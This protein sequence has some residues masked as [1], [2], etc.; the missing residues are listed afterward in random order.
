MA[1]PLELNRQM[2]SPEL[3]R[4]LGESGIEVEAA[5][6]ALEPSRK[7]ASSRPRSFRRRSLRLSALSAVLIALVAAR[8]KA[9]ATPTAGDL[10]EGTYQVA[11]VKR[12]DVLE[13]AN[14]LEVRLLGVAPASNSNPDA[15]AF[16]RDSVSGSE[17]RLQF[18]R[19]RLDADGRYLAYVWVAGP[20]SERLL[21]EELFRAG[22]V[23]SSPATLALCTSSMKRRLTRTAEQRAKR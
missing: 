20:R 13:L 4:Q 2:L 14:H 10:P 1:A 18:D 21:N 6:S 12:A 17:V 8:W 5:L 9:T 11:A 3:L 19:T 16:I 23:D 15:L 22:L 7:P